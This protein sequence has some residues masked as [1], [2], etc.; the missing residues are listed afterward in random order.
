M[1]IEQDE[2]R[3]F[4]S[5]PLRN[6]RRVSCQ[7]YCAVVDKIVTRSVGIHSNKCNGQHSTDSPCIYAVCNGKPPK[8]IIPAHL[9]AG[10]QYFQHSKGQSAKLL[11]PRDSTAPAVSDYASTMLSDVKLLGGAAAAIDRGPP[12]LAPIKSEEPAELKRRLSLNKQLVGDATPSCRMCRL[13][14][15]R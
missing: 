12:P 3:L 11:V 13:T 14:S 15:R 5:F 2:E 10:Y 4:W 1:K 7:H 6:T 9:V 8:G